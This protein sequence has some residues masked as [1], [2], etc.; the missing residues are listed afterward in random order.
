MIFYL[1]RHGQSEGNVRGKENNLIFARRDNSS[2]T[3]K[4]EN[5]VKKIGDSFLYKK[6]KIDKIFTSPLKRTVQTAKILS[7][8]LKVKEIIID[9]NLIDI[10]LGQLE[11][12]SYEQI[13]V[14]FKDFFYLY[15]KD[16]FNTKFP[17]G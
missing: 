3:E 13:K 12:K 2:L 5:Q 11:G 17:G 6:I 10:D 15:Q 1:V 9:E 4:G 8:K 14:L 7:K 16:R